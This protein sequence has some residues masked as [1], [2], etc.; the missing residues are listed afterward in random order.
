VREGGRLVAVGICVHLVP[1]SLAELA[2]R[3]LLLALALL[4]AAAVLFARHLAGPL[5]EV[6]TAA[7]RFGRG[8]L[9][10]RLR[11]RRHDEIGAVG[12][13]FDDMAGRVSRL[14]TSQREL[15][16]NVSHELQTPL[17]R[18]RVAVDLMR[19]GDAARAEEMLNEI[20]HDLGE[21]ERLIDDVM[22]LARL[23]VAGAEPD[24]VV[25]PLRREPVPLAQLVERSVARFRAL[26]DSHPLTLDT[27][28]DLPSLTADPV[29]LRRALDNLLDNARKYSPEGQSIAVAV[30]RTPAGATITVTDR[31]QGIKPDDLQHVFTPFFRGDR[32]RSRTTGGV[33]LG[34]ALTRRVVEAHGGRVTI[35]SEVG[36]GTTVTIDLPATRDARATA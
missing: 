32:S 13:A 12:R 36:A 21:L 8:E 23:D 6:V 24:A 20:T 25:S 31:G 30:R 28:A 33:G 4:V 5:Q 34:L 17:S 29:L 19:D 14:V 10:I 35:A 11:S 1:P 16:A 15:M 26:H 2:V 9:G 7:L 3:P 18:I 27:E 22:T